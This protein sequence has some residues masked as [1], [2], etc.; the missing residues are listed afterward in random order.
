MTTFI[1]AVKV[2]HSGFQFPLSHFINGG[3]LFGIRTNYGEISIT[4]ENGSPFVVIRSNYLELLNKD[5]N[6]LK[7]DIIY[8]KRKILNIEWI[9]SSEQKIAATMISKW[10]LYNYYS[11]YTIIGKKRLNREYNKVF[12][13]EK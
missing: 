2:N 5:L 12:N 13:N 8:E 1:Y 10:C 7:E 11:P 4:R 9:S 6:K 3:Y